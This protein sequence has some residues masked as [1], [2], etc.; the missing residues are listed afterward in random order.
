VKRLCPNA[1][2]AA[3]VQPSHT[4]TTIK[5]PIRHE[6]F[7]VVLLRRLILLSEATGS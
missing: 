4:P 6:W 3:M 5:V 7:I 1:G 2:I